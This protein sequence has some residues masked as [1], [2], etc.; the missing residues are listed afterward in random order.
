MCIAP[1]K[2]TVLAIAAASMAVLSASSCG[3]HDSDELRSRSPRIVS[4]TPENGVSDVDFDGVFA[5]K[6]TY[7]Q[8]IGCKQADIPSITVDGGAEIIDVSTYGPELSITIGK[9]KHSRQ[10][11]VSVPPAV[12][13]GNRRNQEPTLALEYSFSTQGIPTPSGPNAGVPVPG[14]NEAWKLLA[15]LGLG[16][17]LGNQFDAFHNSKEWSGDRFLYPDETAWGN[18]KCT[19]ATFTGLREAGFESVRIPVTWLNMIGDAPDYKIDED[20][21]GRIKEVVGMARDAGLYVIIN[22]HHDE[23]HYIGNEDMGHRWLNI[24]DAATDEKVN[25]EVKDRIRGFWTNVAEAF[26]DEGDYLIF[27]SFNEINDGRWGWGS[28]VPGQAEILNEWNQVFVDAVR[29]TGGRNSTRWIA[30]PP[31]CAGISFLDYFRVPED[32]AGHII[33]AVHSYDPYNFTLAPELP[34]KR[35]GH[36]L[37]KESDEQELKDS[38]LRLY[39][40]YVSKNIPVYLG[41]FGCS[42]REYGTLEWRNYLY[43]LEYFVKMAK[44][45]GV[46]CF[47]WDNGS[48]GYGSERHAY[49]D[50]GTGVYVDHSKEAVDVMVRA[51]YLEDDYYNLQY[52]YNHAPLK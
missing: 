47:L 44:S 25:A 43:Y 46:P 5:V 29:G 32:A 3:G 52:V 11:T 35:W 22:T 33:V 12:I 42:M 39:E 15:K 18:P 49:I 10:Y 16:W 50:H 24:M 8:N 26:R 40:D 36:T 19:A 9:L 6:V 31:Y 38:I 17:N 45:F 51:M 21:L 4:F 30:V 34:Q 41:E 7:D 27:E 28:D 13:Y 37:N 23:D 1:F 14:E 20:W 48:K 2:K